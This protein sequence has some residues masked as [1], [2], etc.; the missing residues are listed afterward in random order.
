[1]VKKTRKRFD[2]GDYMADGGSIP[3]SSEYLDIVDRFNNLKIPEKVYLNG[4]EYKGEVSVINGYNGYTSTAQDG[5]LGV[6]DEVSGNVWNGFKGYLKD[7]DGKYLRAQDRRGL[8]IN[9]YADGG[10]M[11]AI[12]PMLKFIN[13]CY[14]RQGA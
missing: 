1:M 4:K 10:M 8:T 12:Q 9:V 13:S 6:F 11:I 5:L 3:K 2:T 14:P 7:K